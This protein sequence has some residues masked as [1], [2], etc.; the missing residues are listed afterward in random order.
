MTR[1]EILNTKIN[2]NVRKGLEFEFSE[3]LF[4]FGKTLLGRD[5]PAF[6]V[7]DGKKYAMYVGAHHALEYPTENILYAMLY[8]LT[9]NPEAK[10]FYGMNRDILLQKFTFFLI[11]ALNLD[12]IA[13]VMG[14]ALGNVLYDRQLRMSGGDFSCWQANARGVDLNHNYDAG[15]FEY[16][17]IERERGIV[18]GPSLY[19]GEYPESEPESSAVANFYRALAPKLVV[20]LHSQGEEI[21]YSPKNAKTKRFAE[22]F[23]KYSGYLVKTPEGTAAYGGL[24]DYTGA[25]GTPSLT[26][27]I[28]R[29]KN[30]IKISHLGEIYSR[31]RRPL[32]LAPTMF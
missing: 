19:S 28:G 8:D 31:I 13:L 12:G 30:P 2:E 29:G 15:F 16:K 11:P 10:D 32:L 23:A 24:S 26:L 27:E 4:C 3:Y 14:E 22:R 18:P 5:I 6:K 21:F 9:K 17:A 1:R 20:S 25:L 7:G